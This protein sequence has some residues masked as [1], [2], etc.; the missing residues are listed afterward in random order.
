M[1][2]F[3][4]HSRFRYTRLFSSSSA[5]VNIR[6]WIHRDGSLE[7]II[8]QVMN[9]GSKERKIYR[10][11]NIKWIHQLF[12][13]LFDPPFVVVEKNNVQRSTELHSMHSAP[14]SIIIVITSAAH[15]IIKTINRVTIL[16]MAVQNEKRLILRIIGQT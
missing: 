4:H 10:D 14:E 8:K 7:I 11:Q 12:I 15:G 13:F 1:R 16:P 9:R 6:I 2:F 5:I 3:L